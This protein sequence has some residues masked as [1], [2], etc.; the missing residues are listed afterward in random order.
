MFDLVISGGRIVDGA[1]RAAFKSDVGIKADRITAVGDL[2][3]AAA[4]MRLDVNGLVVA[5]GFIDLHTHSDCTLLINGAAESQVHQ[6]VTLEVVGQCGYSAAPAST[7]FRSW[8]TCGSC[9]ATGGSRKKSACTS[10]CL[11]IKG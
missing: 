1:S 10:A 7:V 3:D 4:E 8:W 9:R 6:G 11:R 5:P 2:A